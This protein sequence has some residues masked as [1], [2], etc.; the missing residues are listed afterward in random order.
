M[1]DA[2]ARVYNPCV[3]TARQEVDTEFLEA[4]RPAMKN[5]QQNNLV[6]NKVEGKA[7]PNS[8]F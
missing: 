8:V 4:P 2:G 3:T 7:I 6:S 1:P 5:H